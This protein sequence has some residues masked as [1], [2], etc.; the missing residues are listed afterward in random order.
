M[1]LAEDSGSSVSA[2]S[3]APIMAKIDHLH[4][5]YLHASDSP[6]MAFFFAFDWTGYGSWRKSILVSLSAK[7]KL[8]FIDGKLVKPKEN[9][10]FFNLWTRCNDM[11]FAWLLNSLTKK[12]RSSVIHSKS[13]HDLWEQLEKRYGQSNLAQL[14][15]LQKQI[16]E[17]IQGSNNIATYFNNMKAIWDEIDLLD[18][19]VVCSCVD[20]KCGA[21]EK[22][23]ALEE[24]QKLVQFLMGLN[25]TYTACRGNIMMM[26]PSPDIDR[27]YFLLLQEERQ[28]SIQPMG[29]LPTDSTF[30]SIARQSSI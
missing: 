2:D 19:R 15:D 5:Y 24:R 11:V 6:G 28:R 22:N 7:N 10:E 20:Y 23:S 29:I 21:V 13:A 4:P 17:T 3:P 8:G 16:M 1:V 26:N 25:E 30:F 9:S 27:A 18:S 14:F 12:I